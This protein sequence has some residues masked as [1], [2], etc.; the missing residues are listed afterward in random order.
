M[1]SLNHLIAE[2][3]GTFYSYYNLARIYEYGYGVKQNYDVA[4]EYYKKAF[5][6][7]SIQFFHNAYKCIE[8]LEI[9]IQILLWKLKCKK[10]IDR[11]GLSMLGNKVLNS[12]LSF[13]SVINN[14]FLNFNIL[15]LHPVSITMSLNRC[16]GETPLLY[17]ILISLAVGS[18]GYFFP[19]IIRYL[20]RTFNWTIQINGVQFVDGAIV[21]RED[22]Q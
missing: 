6:V 9:S 3:D 14:K 20:A 17:P 21:E 7:K 16:Y 11:I 13:F 19:A 10:I 1:L 8:G 22:T 2:T 15:K 4:A 18:I 12:I 5:D